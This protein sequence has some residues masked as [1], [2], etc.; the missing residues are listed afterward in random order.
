MSRPQVSVQPVTPELQPEF[1]ALWTAARVEA[2]S[3]PDA[4]QRAASEGRIADALAR[5]DV[6]GLPRPDRRHGRRLHGADHEP[7]VRRS[8]TP[9]PCP[10]TSSTSCPSP[11]ARA[12]PTPCCHGPPA[13]AETLG[14]E[15]IGT[16]VPAQDREANRFFA[17]LGFSSSRRAP[18]HPHQRPAP[19]ARRR[20]APRRPRPGALRRRRSLR[21][22]AARGDVAPDRRLSRPGPPV[23][24]VAGG[25]AL[26]RPGA[27]ARIRQVIREVQTRVP[28]RR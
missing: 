9:R 4:A 15:Q 27:F 26:R 5:D 25:R 23:A 3:T 17:R 21:A 12:W 13:Y 22:R 7:A 16:C 8:S 20:G 2:G 19:P 28:P 24:L 14:C 18:G 1:T 6:H 10:S 11:A